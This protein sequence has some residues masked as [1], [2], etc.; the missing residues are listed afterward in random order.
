MMVRRSHHSAPP[1]GSHFFFTPGVLG[2]MAVLSSSSLPA[3][4]R[5]RGC[6]ELHDTASK[7]AVEDTRNEVCAELR[8]IAYVAR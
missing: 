3:V 8:A 1:A 7:T 2:V 4:A 5:I 6:I